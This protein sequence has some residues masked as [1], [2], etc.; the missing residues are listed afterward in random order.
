MISV[1][2][3]TIDGREELFE[4]C[5][6]DYQELSPPDTEIIVV[7][8]MPNCGSAWQKGADS[9]HGDYL[10]LT[11]DDIE[12]LEGWWEAAL[13]AWEYGAVPAARVFRPDGGLESAV[14]WETPGADGAAA[15]LCQ[16]PFCSMD[17]W[18]AHIGPMIPTQYYS[19]NWFTDKAEAA[20]YRCRLK[21]GY[22][23]VHH[24]PRY[25]RQG[26]QEQMLHDRSQYE[27]Y[28]RHGYTWNDL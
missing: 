27:Y 6:R 12:P 10:H 28:Q 26:E 9:A 19:D 21:H 3:P 20:G 1:V 11:A 18:R 25:L 4:Q 17:T 23:F 5:V 7:K 16:I 14:R 15:F 8:N 13:L 24:R 22:D 2:I